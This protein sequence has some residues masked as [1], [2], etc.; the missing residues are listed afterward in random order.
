MTN[1][2][3]RDF[4][5]ARGNPKVTAL[6]RAVADD[7]VARVR[8]LL[9]AGVPPDARGRKGDTPLILAMALGRFEAAQ[10]LLGR[11]AAPDLQNDDG[12]TAMIYAASATAGAGRLVGLLA[13]YGAN[14]HIPDKHGDTPLRVAIDEDNAEAVEALLAAG[15]TAADTNAAGYSALGYAAAGK[16]AAL[17][18]LLRENPDLNA[19]NPQG[20]PPLHMAMAWGSAACVRLLLD[21]GADPEIC[22]H[23]DG[24]PADSGLAYALRNCSREIHDMARAANR[25]FAL[26]RSL[27][28]KRSDGECL[29][30]MNSGECPLGLIDR[31]RET[32]LSRV[33]K[34]TALLD[35]DTEFAGRTALLEPLLKA[36]AD[37]N[38]VV[39]LETG[40]TALFMLHEAGDFTVAELDMLARHGARFDVRNKKGQTPAEVLREKGG[41]AL[42]DRMEEILAEREAEVSKATATPRKLAKIRP[43]SFD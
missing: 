4:E 6:F 20:I 14:P 7:D 36:G 28:V 34:M 13:Q 23:K 9:D 22:A 26:L 41:G 5:C 11:K 25:R 3:S 30:H 21:A 33:V 16:A 40:E 19:R 24:K 10:E 37:V 12:E 18:V 8:A 17:A 31:D 39:N 29:E 15:C 27:A 2:L 32:A 35:T 43:I 38:Q 1:T 42:A